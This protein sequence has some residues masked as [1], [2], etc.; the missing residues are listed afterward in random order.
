MQITK[1][2]SFGFFGF[3][4]SPCRP[5]KRDRN[6]ILTNLNSPLSTLSFF[7]RRAVVGREGFSYQATH[8]AKYGQEGL[9]ESPLHTHAEVVEGIRFGE[10]IRRQV[11]V[12]PPP[13]KNEA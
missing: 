13:K 9:L 2:N 7:V 12:T 4:L 3:R 6:G 8:M 11:G 1:V 10:E 5:R